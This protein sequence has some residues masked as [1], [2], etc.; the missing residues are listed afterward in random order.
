MDLISVIITT[1]NREV[2]IVKRAL[3]SALKQTYKNI[4]IIVVD[5]SYESFLESRLIKEE[6]LKHECVSYIINDKKHGACEAR[7]L[8]LKYAKGDFVAFLDDDD[9]WYPTKLQK[10]LAL[11]IDSR[12]AFVYCGFSFVN[13]SNGMEKVYM[14][15]KRFRGDVYPELLYKNFVDQLHCR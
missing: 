8:G 3:A 9:E 1:H 4:E 15:D 7:N 6:C 14:L 2:N 11:F 12:I 5:D 10:Q 13:D